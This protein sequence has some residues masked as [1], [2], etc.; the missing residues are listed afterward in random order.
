MSG[1]WIIGGIVALAI[2]ALVFFPPPVSQEPRESDL[3]PD[4]VDSFSG[5]SSSESPPP[6]LKEENSDLDIKIHEQELG[7]AHLGLKTN[8]AIKDI[9]LNQ[10]LSGGPGKDGIPAVRKPKFLPLSEKPDSV[11]LDTL[12]LVVGKNPVKFYPYNILVWH[13]I[14]DDTVDGIPVAVTFCPL[15]GSGIVF[16]RTVNNQELEFGVSGLL[17]E[18]NLVMYDDKTE[19]LWSQASGKAIVGD[20]TGTQLKLFPSSLITFEQFSQNHSDG[21]VLSDETG[22][23]RNYEFYPYGSYERNAS[24]YFPIS[25]FDNSLPA[26]EIVFAIPLENAVALFP[27]EKLKTQKQASLEADGKQIELTLNNGEITTLV[28]GEEKPGYYS[29]YFSVAVSNDNLVIWDL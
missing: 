11:K 4:S 10:L 8:T 24:I 20:F 15:C 6:D 28:D 22:H 14:V 21:L 9:P 13:E 7:F 17:H 5:D 3:P 2:I 25:D 19:S 23:F 27:F 12:G 16:E 1:A 18:S 26:K 29:M